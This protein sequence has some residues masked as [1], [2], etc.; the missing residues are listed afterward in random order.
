MVVIA[1]ILFLIHFTPIKLAVKK[2]HQHNIR[3]E[4]G[5]IKYV[6][7]KIFES[8]YGHV[9]S[10][11]IFVVSALSSAVVLYVFWNRL[12]FWHRVGILVLVLFSAI[13]F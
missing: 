2:F 12:K 3:V 5:D 10:F 11:G 8:F 4:Y 1:F 13:P 9:V 7:F 6:K